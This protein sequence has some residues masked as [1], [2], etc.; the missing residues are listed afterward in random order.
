[1]KLTIL[2]KGYGVD[3]YPEI[4]LYE[5][6]KYIGSRV[7]KN[8]CELDFDIELKEKSN[9]LVIDY[10]NK[11]E[12]HTK[13]N[14]GVIVEDQYIEFVGLRLDDILLNNWMLTESYYYPRYF[15]GFLSQCADAPTKV[16]SQL[17]CHF[18]GQLMLQP[19][20]DKNKFWEWYY[21]QRRHIYVEQMSI[22]D[23]ERNEQYAGSTDPLSE[24]I[25]EI[26]NIIN[27]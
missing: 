22:R 4:K 24:L 21:H 19:L 26:K 25:T 3:I 17:I 5:N 18:P 20:P 14:N 2:A 12:H 9:N 16:R 10:F 7:V 15:S 23:Q 13:V 6:E 11:L 8:Y 1:M 27:V